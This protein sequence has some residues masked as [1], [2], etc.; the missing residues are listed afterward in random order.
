MN[1]RQLLG[2]IIS[3]LIVSCHNYKKELQLGNMEKELT[4]IKE[5]LIRENNLKASYIERLSMI[6]V[7]KNKDFKNADLQINQIADKFINQKKPDDF[8]Q[9][10]SDEEIKLKFEEAITGMTTTFKSLGEPKSLL[11]QMLGDNPHPVF[12]ELSSI[13]SLR[14]INLLNNQIKILNFQ[15]KLQRILYN[16]MHGVDNF[17]YNTRI[18]DNKASTV[19]T[20]YSAYLLYAIVDSDTLHDYFKLSKITLNGKEINTK[21]YFENDRGVTTFNFVPT[22]PGLYEWRVIS[23][24]RNY[25]GTYKGTPFHGKVTIEKN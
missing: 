13:D 24:N 22:E 23:I 14:K 12:I 15:L 18:I 9:K 21:Y 20:K 8:L 3:V 5:M 17:C 6:Y 7:S 10:F 25:D 19:G 2:I 11:W 1:M 4:E 16:F